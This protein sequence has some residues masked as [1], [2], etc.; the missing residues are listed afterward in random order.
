VFVACNN[1]Q[2]IEVYD[3][4]TFTL[5][6][7]LTVPGLGQI[8]Y[9]LAACISNNCLYASD[10][11]GNSIHRV[12]LSGSQSAA[13]K[14]WSV[15]SHP[16]GLSV[17]KAHNVVIACQGANKLQEYTTLGTLVREISPQQAGV[18]RP[19]HAIQLSTGDYVVCH[20][21]S[22]GVVSVVG[23]DGQVM[24]TYGHSQASCVGQM[25]SPKS[26]AVTNNGDILLVDQG[27]N[28]ILSVNS[29]LSSAQVLTWS[30]ND[31]LQQPFGLCLD[32]SRHRFYISE[33]GGGRVLTFESTCAN[34]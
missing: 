21:M 1:S 23:I 17:N 2:Q 9:G 3:A 15:A 12:D 7:H 5:Q 27:N 28:R 19:W 33:N 13:V 34:C 14:M 30:G 8:C 29:S 22:Q 24:C 26:L 25:S 20:N 31:K 10:F 16:A 11:Y 6:R 32:E 4:G 18:T